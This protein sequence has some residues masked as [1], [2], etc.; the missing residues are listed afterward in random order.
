[1][2]W[3]TAALPTLHTEVPRAKQHSRQTT[4]TSSASASFGAI[5]ANR[6]SSTFSPHRSTD[7]ALRR[8]QPPLKQRKAARQLRTALESLEGSLHGRLYLR[9]SAGH[10]TYK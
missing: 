2:T 8:W 9:P 5:A 7:G 6:H 4:S 3:P 10:A 1:M